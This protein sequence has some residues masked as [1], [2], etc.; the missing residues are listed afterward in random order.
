MTLTLE[1]GGRIVI[2]ADAGIQLL[3]YFVVPADA[4]PM[5][6]PTGYS[7]GPRIREDDSQRPP[8]SLLPREKG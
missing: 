1:E 7:M 3:R 2:P 6:F 4:E 5:S 8:N